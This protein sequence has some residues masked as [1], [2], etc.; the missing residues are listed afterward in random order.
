MQPGTVSVMPPGLAAQLS[1]QE[2]T[3]LLAFLKATRSGAN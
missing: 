1:Q 2:L 3:D